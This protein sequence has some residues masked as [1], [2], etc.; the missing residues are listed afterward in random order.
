MAIIAMSETKLEEP[1][2]CRIR[3]AAIPGKGSSKNRRVFTVTYV[4]GPD[5]APISIEV[6]R[7]VAYQETQETWVL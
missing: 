6:V 5:L 4:S 3:S 2:D 1:N 7:L